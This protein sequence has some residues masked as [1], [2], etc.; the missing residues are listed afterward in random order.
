M[1][2]SY[3]VRTSDGD[4]FWITIT[5]ALSGMSVGMLV[6]GCIV[7]IAAYLLFGTPL[8]I[9]PFLYNEFLEEFGS[10]TLFWVLV[11]I[12]VVF[13]LFR[14]SVLVGRTEPSFAL[15]L[16]LQGLVFLVAFELLQCVGY[17]Q[18]LSAYD[19]ALL[20]EAGIEFGN[21]WELAW[22]HVT[23]TYD[24]VEMLFATLYIGYTGAFIPAAVS[25]VLANIVRD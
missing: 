8:L 18:G 2:E 6:A 19:P 10:A 24:S 22:M 21:F 11:A 7:L 25:Y 4:S 14:T 15:E 13:A 17:Y 5:S 23:A 12:Q 9:W 3:H 20:R 1:Y 16:V